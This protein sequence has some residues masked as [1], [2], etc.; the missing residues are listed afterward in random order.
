[1]WDDEMG[2]KVHLKY[3]SVLYN[4][5]LSGLYVQQY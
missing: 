2:M 1:M 3:F 5:F 4:V